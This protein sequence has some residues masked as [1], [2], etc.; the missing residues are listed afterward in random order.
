M[1]GPMT[2]TKASRRG[3][4]CPA[5][6][7]WR[8][9]GRYGGEARYDQAVAA[10]NQTLKLI[11]EPAT[12]WNAS[13]WVLAAIADACFLGGY[14]TSAVEALEHVTRCPSAVGNPFLH[15]RLGQCYFE[16]GALDRAADQLA[17]AYMLTP[18]SRATLHVRT[19]AS[20][21]HVGRP[22][23]K[24]MLE[25][26]NLKVRQMPNPAVEPT[27]PPSVGLPPRAARVSAHLIRWAS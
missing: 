19:R 7:H 3:P 21:G 1:L 4:R 12:D 23:E 16:K 15:L 5:S 6:S 11:P 22:R 8:Y 2:S 24:S 26:L 20:R 10:Y 17:R 9:R 27:V 14:Y 13:I 25:A 18:A